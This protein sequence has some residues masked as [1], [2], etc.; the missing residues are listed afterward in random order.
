MNNTP[1]NDTEPEQLDEIAAWEETAERW[2]VLAQSAIMDLLEVTQYAKNL[3]ER[4]EAFEGGPS[5]MM[6]VVDAAQ[7]ER[8]EAETKLEEALLRIAHLE[9]QIGGAA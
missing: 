2:R 3:E 5:A 6:R 8:N 7:A 4:L 1:V 9:T